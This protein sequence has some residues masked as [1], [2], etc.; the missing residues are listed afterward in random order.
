VARFGIQD[1][2][3][4]LTDNCLRPLRWGVTGMS[5]AASGFEPVKDM[6]GT[7]DLF[8]R[9]YEYAKES[10]QDGL[11]AAAALV[12]GEGDQR[13]PLAVI[14]DLPSITFTRRDPTEAELAA[15]HIDLAD[16]MYGP[17]LTAVQWQKGERG[18]Q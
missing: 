8:G 5:I 16:D 12:M 2:G 1:V 13:T 7:P 15:L 11:A 6:I 14:T 17:F 18:R 9:P 4:V 10:I 3:V